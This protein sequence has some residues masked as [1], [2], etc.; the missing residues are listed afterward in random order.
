MAVREHA[1]T[2]DSDAAADGRPWGAWS[3][4]P[5]LLGR[6]AEVEALRA[7]LLDPAVGLVT[8]VGPAGCGKT[9]LARAVASEL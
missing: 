3:R 6:E 2:I 8:V 5:S 9:R 1:V 7:L 4:L